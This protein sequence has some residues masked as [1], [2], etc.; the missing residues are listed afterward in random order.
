[1]VVERL[2]ICEFLEEEEGRLAAGDFLL[3]FWFKKAGCLA[4]RVGL[5]YCKNRLSKFR[6][7]NSIISTT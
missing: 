4:A 1:V 3:L 7:Q 2:R 6:F 5:S